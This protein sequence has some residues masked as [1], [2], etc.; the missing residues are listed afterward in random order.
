MSSFAPQRCGTLLVTLLCCFLFIFQFYIIFGSLDIIKRELQLLK[1]RVDDLQKQVEAL[2]G[3]NST[4]LAAAGGPDINEL[5]K[6][7]ES[8]LETFQID[9]ERLENMLSINVPPGK[10]IFKLFNCY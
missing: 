1:P 10:N 4:A 5:S 2:K 8:T 6:K 3:S 9:H 7:L